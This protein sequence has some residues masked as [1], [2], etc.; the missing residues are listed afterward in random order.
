MYVFKS[1][2]MSD[3]GEETRN[4][5]NYK[6]LNTVMLKKGYGEKEASEYA[7][8]CLNYF[9]F[10]E[11]VLDNILSTEERDFFHQMED[12][13]IVKRN[14]QEEILIPLRYESIPLKPSKTKKIW[15]MFHWVLRIADIYEMAEEEEVAEVSE[16]YSVYKNLSDEVWERAAGV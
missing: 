8:K 2:S 14:G 3:R 1:L 11:M 5:M 4:I 6:T 12:D 13:G 7:N 10:S 9:G 15:R 16:Q